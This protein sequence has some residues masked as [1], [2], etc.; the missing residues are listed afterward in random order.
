ME[1]VKKFGVPAVFAVGGVKASELVGLTKPWQQ[2]AAAILFAGGALF[3]HS[4][5]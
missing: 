4:K 1:V 2:I 3:L 5:I